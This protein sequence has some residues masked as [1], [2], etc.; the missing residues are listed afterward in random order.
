MYRIIKEDSFERKTV[1]NTHMDLL[2]SYT[3]VY[4]FRFS[5]FSIPNYFFCD[6]IFSFKETVV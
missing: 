3:A 4:N 2:A 1:I 5:K 6:K